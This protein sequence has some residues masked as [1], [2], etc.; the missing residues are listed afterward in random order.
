MQK[1]CLFDTTTVHFVIKVP[2]CLLVIISCIQFYI[3]ELKYCLESN[4]TS[5]VCKHTFMHI[6]AFFHHDVYFTEPEW[7]SINFGIIL[8]DICAGKLLSAFCVTR[9]VLTHQ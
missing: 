2:R 6:C 9:H 3:L 4:I 8:C 5:G 7:A 1:R